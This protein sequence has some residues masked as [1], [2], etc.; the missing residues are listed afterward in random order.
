MAGRSFRDKVN[1]TRKPEGFPGK[2]VLNGMNT[3]H[4]GMDEGVFN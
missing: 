2:P 1:Q 4:A 3:C